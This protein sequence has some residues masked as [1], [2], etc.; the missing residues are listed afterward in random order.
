MFSTTQALLY[1]KGIID[2]RTVLRIRMF[3]DLYLTSH[4]ETQA[5][6][7]LIV[8]GG[9][10]MLPAVPCLL[11]FSETAC[12]FERGQ[13][14]DEVSS[15]TVRALNVK[16][17]IWTPFPAASNPP[18]SPTTG[19]KNARLSDYL[20]DCDA[21]FA[22][23]FTPFAN[24]FLTVP[25][26]AGAFEVESLRHYLFRGIFYDFDVIEDGREVVMRFSEDLRWDRPCP[27]YAITEKNF[28]LPPK[29][30]QGL[31]LPLAY[32]VFGLWSVIG[33]EDVAATFGPL[34]KNRP[35][36][37]VCMNGAEL[38]EVKHEPDGVSTT[39]KHS[40]HSFGATNDPGFNVR[41]HTANGVW[42]AMCLG[43]QGR[44]G[45][46]THE[47]SAFGSHVD[48]IDI[49][50]PGGEFAS[51]GFH[52]LKRI[53]RVR[54][55]ENFRAATVIFPV[56]MADGVTPLPTRG[57]TSL[58]N[59]SV[60]HAKEAAKTIDGDAMSWLRDDVVLGGLTV[61]KLTWEMGVEPNLGAIG[62]LRPFVAWRRVSG[63][64]SISFRLEIDFQSNA[65]TANGAQ[66]VTAANSPAGRIITTMSDSTAVLSAAVHAERWEF[67]QRA[68]S[69]APPLGRGMR[70]SVEWTHLGTGNVI[71]IIQVGW[72]VDYNP[73]R[74]FSENRVR[75]WNRVTPY[76]LTHDP[77]IDR[78][79]SQAHNPNKA[80]FY[81]G[82][83]QV[84]DSAN[85]FPGSIP[86]TGVPAAIPNIICNPA[87]VIRHLIWTYGGGSL[88]NLG[89]APK[90][91][92]LA[93]LAYQT[94]ISG[95]D[96]RDFDKAIASLDALVSEGAGAT[97]KFRIA[98]SIG[99]HTTVKTLV[100]AIERSIPGLHTF[101]I[102][103]RFP[104][105]VEPRGTIGCIFPRAGGSVTYRRPLSL[106]NDV[107][108][109]VQRFT[110]L[111]HVV[112]NIKIQYGQSSQTG[113]L[114]R[115]LWFA[116]DVQDHGWP[117]NVSLAGN[118]SG[119]A[120][121]T[122]TPPNG[123][124][125]R[126]AVESHGVYNT[127]EAELVSPF[128][129]RAQ[130]AIA[131]RNSILEWRCCR[132][133]RLFLTCK[134]QVA[135]LLPGDV[136]QLNNDSDAFLEGVRFPMAHLLL[137]EAS[138]A[139]SW[140]NRTFLVERVAFKPSAGGDG[141]AVLVQAIWNGRAFV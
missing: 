20:I 105:D 90:P 114:T 97:E 140:N 124:F 106:R 125:Y 63:S 96:A 65:A 119:A 86:W 40:W 41:P 109:M 104:S 131:L 95:G 28:K 103:T 1:D 81:I 101:R 36:F 141:S 56:K 35:F 128:I 59:F 25:A 69:P 136:F 134:M 49:T 26:P 39:T 7:D 13:S 51:T 80:G 98:M 4:Q 84:A 67:V 70:F 24:L 138:S 117:A 57:V 32:G 71:D 30:T 112:N 87:E 83:G 17:P 61:R 126:M 58:P 37:P 6:S 50:T 48:Q 62:L 92:A 60:E 74:F 123:L 27:P 23:N 129:Y 5:P 64:A 121:P 107:V 78:I 68:G 42:Q 19:V 135:D 88:D 52:D 77:P 108:D 55:R 89:A 111:R 21:T 31:P 120:D 91:I 2:A 76:T 53:G 22:Y 54:L 137:T 12:G 29:E 100:R 132:R 85:G 130:E 82:M 99:Q 93:E 94:P 16:L 9:I 45:L 133:L 66:T 110:P 113:T 46:V 44:V 38:Y 14:S 116:H 15:L 73:T 115:N 139:S 122:G 75:P 10:N 11:E 34:H 102:P 3:N 72:L 127:K 18:G 43:G 79:L 118:S 33:M 47:Q 8:Q